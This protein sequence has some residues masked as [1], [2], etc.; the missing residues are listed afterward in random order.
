[1][2]IHARMQPAAEVGGDYYDVIELGD[3]DVLNFL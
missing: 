1:V 3:G 2:S